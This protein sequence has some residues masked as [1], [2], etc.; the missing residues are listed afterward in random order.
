LQRHAER[1][2]EESAGWLAGLRDRHV[3]RALA[4]NHENPSCPWTIDMLADEIT[5]SRSAF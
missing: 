2:P 5:L 3:E 1:M 4:L